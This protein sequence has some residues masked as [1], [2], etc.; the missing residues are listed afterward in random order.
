VEVTGIIM[1]ITLNALYGD[2]EWGHSG[3]KRE[4][5]E[6]IHSLIKLFSSKLRDIQGERQN[7]AHSIELNN[8]QLEVLIQACYW[9]LDYNK[10]S[11]DYEYK[12]SL[13]YIINLYEKAKATIAPEIS[14]LHREVRASVKTDC[15][16]PKKNRNKDTVLD[17]FIVGDD[18]DWG[19]YD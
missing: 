9:D 19:I 2:E 3:F 14:E 8:K 13:G 5:M 6:R 16:P 11:Y 12:R 4:Y 18:W 17:D 7:A 10:L 15:P 1:D